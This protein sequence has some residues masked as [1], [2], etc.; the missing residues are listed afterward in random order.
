MRV[1]GLTF[2]P[3]LVFIAVAGVAYVISG[4]G[5]FKS[6]QCWM[7]DP[8]VA[9]LTFKNGLGQTRELTFSIKGQASLIRQSWGWQFVTDW[10]NIESI[11]A[12]HDQRDPGFV[13]LSVIFTPES[14]EPSPW[15]FGLLDKRCFEQLRSRYGDH[16]RFVVTQ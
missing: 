16:L 8:D 1:K 2:W 14:G 13:R 9:S 15:E 6:T 4:V 10:K 3:L 12:Q 5:D 7:D 11:V